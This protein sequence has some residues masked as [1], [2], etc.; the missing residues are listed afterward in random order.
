MDLSE[1]CFKENHMIGSQY[2]QPE[3]S[4]FEWHKQFREV[5]A[6]VVDPGAYGVVVEFVP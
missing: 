3:K 5:V 1:C 4:G 6:R 2:A